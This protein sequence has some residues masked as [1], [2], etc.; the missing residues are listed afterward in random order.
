MNTFDTFRLTAAIALAFGLA[1][2]VG[3]SGGDLAIAEPTED[4]LKDAEAE[5][6]AEKIKIDIEGLERLSGEFTEQDRYFRMWKPAIAATIPLSGTA[7][8][9]GIAA[10][11]EGAAYGKVDAGSPDMVADMALTV[12]FG[13]SK[14]TGAMWDFHDK[15]GKSGGGSIDLR[16]NQDSTSV[17]ASGTSTIHWGDSNQIVSVDVDAYFLASQYGIKGDITAN[18]LGAGGEVE[19]KGI[20]ILKNDK[21]P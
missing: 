20:V 8:Y 14:V 10:F 17:K 9:N 12:N 1:G 5:T 15:D 19:S 4:V 18:S 16:G 13:T 21:A 7:T 11:G 2:C 3:G 6:S